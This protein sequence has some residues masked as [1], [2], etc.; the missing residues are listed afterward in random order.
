MINFTDNAIKEINRLFKRI[1]DPKMAIR[2]T[3]KDESYCSNLI[4]LT[5]DSSIGNFDKTFN[6]NGI[7]VVVNRKI[8]VKLQNV[9]IDY[10]ND[11]LARGFKFSVPDKSKN[12]DCHL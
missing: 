4:T 2:L 9:I 10:T 6:I 5:F 1:Q 3:V 11:L 8:Y 7:K 12:C